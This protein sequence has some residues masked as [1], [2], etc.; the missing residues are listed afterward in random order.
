M[1]PQKLFKYPKEYGLIDLKGFEDISI[2]RV[3]F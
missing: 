3:S 1:L 2:N